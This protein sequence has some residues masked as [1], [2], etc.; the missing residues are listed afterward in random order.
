VSI[1]LRLIGVL[2][3]ILLVQGP[4]TPVFA[5]PGPHCG[6][7]AAPRFVFGFANLKP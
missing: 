3:T 6:S 4:S 1:G 7:G 2:S 5:Q